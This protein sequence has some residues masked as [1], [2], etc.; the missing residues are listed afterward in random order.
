MGFF[1]HKP[2]PPNLEERR[3]I[4]LESIARSLN[5]AF[6]FVAVAFQI[7]AVQENNDMQK[8]KLVLVAVKGKA[9][10]G[11]AAAGPTG[12]SDSAPQKFAV[13]GVD[14]AG[15]YGAPLAPGATIVLSAGAG[16]KGSPG[17]LSQDPTPGI[18]NFTDPNGVART[19]IPSLVSGVFTPNT[20]TP[21]TLDPFA[22]TFAITK[23]DGTP[24][25]TGSAQFQTEPGVE[26]SEVIGLPT[27]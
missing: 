25:D 11:A 15:M 18:F 17:S 14:A 16:A 1:D 27:S 7:F 12:I 10:A 6:P 13:F 2:K 20:A 5:R 3:T 24:G 23:A 21:D 22:V 8:G 9:R 19:S 4:A 26:V